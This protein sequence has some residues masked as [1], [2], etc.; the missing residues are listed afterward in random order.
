MPFA[1]AETV[2]R[3]R[4]GPGELLLVEPGRRAIL[5]T[6]R[7]RPGRSARS[8]STTRP[9]DVRGPDRDARRRWPG[10]RP[11]RADRPRHALPR[12]SRRRARPARHQDDGPRGP[13]A[14]VEHG[15][16]HADAGRGRLD[17]PVADHLRQ[18]FAQVTNPAIDPERERMVMDLRVELGRRPALLG[19]PP[20]GPRTLRLQRPIVADLAGLLA[21]IRVSAGHGPDARCDLG[22][23]APDGG[24]GGRP[25]SAR[26]TTRSRP[27]A[28]GTAVLVL[29]DRA[30]SIDRLPVPSIL[31]AGAVHTALTDAGLRGRTDIVVERRRHPRR[32]RDGDGPRGRRDGG[33][34]APGHRAGRA[35]WPARAAPR[36][37]RPTGRRQP[38]S[39][40]SRPACAR[41]WPG[42]ASARSRRT[43]AGRSS[44]SSISMPDVVARCFPTA[45][46][47]PGRTTL[48]DLAERG[49]RR[50]AAAL[51]MPRTGRRPRAAAARSGLRAVPGRRRGAPLLAA[52]RR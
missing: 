5:R 31:A 28:A 17:R 51:A 34:P 35:S 22:T 7:Q 6:P 9:T 48:A 49:L 44:M 39:R 14:A 41:P 29:T 12:R 4:L 36:R 42:W 21:A 20:R 27:R 16:R 33:P 38:R 11:P 37:S 47:W 25:R 32:P 23:G 2:R 18:A 26:P 15:R 13:R 45:A 52:D 10:R 50:R 40:R 1:A 46:A 24:S 19:G 30:W 8:R 43:S 3:G